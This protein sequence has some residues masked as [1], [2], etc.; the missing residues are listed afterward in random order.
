[1]VFYYS[2]NA[3]LLI[4]LVVAGLIIF[5]VGRYLQIFRHAARGQKKRISNSR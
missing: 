2:W 1:M 5:G 3:S 4:A